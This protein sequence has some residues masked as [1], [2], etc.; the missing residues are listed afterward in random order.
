M[1]NLL[2]AA[3]NSL[4]QQL[5]GALD[6]SHPIDDSR[7]KELF[8]IMKNEHIV[9][10]KAELKAWAKS[11]GWADNVA[12]K[13]GALGEKIGNGGVV[14]VSNKDTWAHDILSKWKEDAEVLNLEST[15]Q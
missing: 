6:F 9:L 15:K 1:D 12:E 8:K 11:I 10:D 7:V 4:K 2:K 3:L 14:Q 13:F 5:N